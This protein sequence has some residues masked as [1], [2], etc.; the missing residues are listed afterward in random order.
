MEL[1]LITSKYIFVIDR[2]KNTTMMYASATSEIEILFQ[3][4]Q[5]LGFIESTFF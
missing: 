5:S 2:N 3:R 4:E 1:V